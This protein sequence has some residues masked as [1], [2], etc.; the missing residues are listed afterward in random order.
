MNSRKLT[1][2]ILT[3]L[4]A[5]IVAAQVTPQSG[6]LNLKIPL[7]NYS[8]TKN[9]L[10]LDI[11]LSYTGGAGIKV[12]DQASEIGLGWSLSAGGEVVRLKVGEADDQKRL[13]IDEESHVM[14]GI[15]NTPDLTVDDG[16]TKLAWN[17][18][19]PSSSRHT[20]YDQAVHFDREHDV[21]M[22]NIEGRTG[23]FVLAKDLY[24][25][26]LLLEKS[27]IKIVTMEQVPPN[28]ELGTIA[29]FLLTDENGIRYTFQNRLLSAVLNYIRSCHVDPTSF[30]VPFPPFELVRYNVVCDGPP[31]ATPRNIIL[32]NAAYVSQDQQYEVL[33]PRETGYYIADAWYL[34]EIRN[35]QSNKVIKFNYEEKNYAANEDIF[36]STS[37]TDFYSKEGHRQ[38]TLTINENYQSLKYPRLASIEMPGNEKV[39][40]SYNKDRKDNLGKKSL[41]EIRYYE[42]GE[43]K[44]KYE[45]RHGYFY[46]DKMLDEALL[47]AD[48]YNREIALSLTGLK[49]SAPDGTE[50]PE[51]KFEYYTGQQG[52][53]TIIFPERHTFSRDH[54][55]YYNY[56][57]LSN[58]ITNG[59]SH[60]I[61]LPPLDEYLQYP[62]LYRNPTSD[63]NMLQTGMLKKVSTEYGGYTEY[64]YEPNYANNN[65]TDILSGGLRV[66]KI[67]SHE[68][69]TNAVLNTEY[70]YLSNTGFS[71]GD[72]YEVPVYNNDLRGLWITPNYKRYKKAHPNL[73][74]FV[75]AS[76]PNITSLPQLGQTL[77]KRIE[78]KAID[79]LLKSSPFLSNVAVLYRLVTAL[80]ATGLFTT[81]AY[82]EVDF[83]SH[84]QSINFINSNNYLTPTYSR[85]EEITTG[86]VRGVDSRN[87]KSIYEYYS[88]AETPL[89]V[90]T[91][92]FPYSNKTRKISWAY[93]LPKITT[94]MD[95]TGKKVKE[96]EFIYDI[97]QQEF[98]DD[99]YMSKK[100]ASPISLVS[101]DDADNGEYFTNYS[102]NVTPEIVRDIYYPIIGT[103]LLKAEKV[104]VYD[105][106]GVYNETVSNM[107]YNLQNY[108]QNYAKSINS[109]GN[110]IEIKT[111]FPQDYT[112]PGALSDMTLKNIVAPAVSSE[113][114]QTK[115]GGTPELLN[116]TV[117]EYSTALNGDYVPGKLY[118]LQSA[119]PVALAAIGGFNPSQ[120]VRNSSLIVPVS[121]IQYDASGLPTE[122]KDLQGNKTNSTMYDYSSRYPVAEIM[123]AG[124]NEVAYT[125]FETGTTGNWTLGV[126]TI[127]TGRCP[128][129]N[130][131]LVL[132]A[133]NIT[134]S[135]AITKEYILS[136]WATTTD[137]TVNGGISPTLTGPTLNGWT[138][139][140]YRLPAGSATTVIST[141]NNYNCKIDELRLYP[142]NATIS[143]AT[144]KVF[145][146]KTSTCD[147]NNRLKYF[148]YDGLGRLLKEKDELG[149]VVKT[150]EYHYKQ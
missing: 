54:W 29:G 18:S 76:V 11:S 111:Y 86:T 34:S 3:L 46:K 8:D 143:T 117:A 43:L 79:M 24:K 138:L 35:L 144:Y 90:P 42:S 49:K 23:K 17:P 65:G 1:L 33:V 109:M 12:N 99:R 89:L 68:P 4:V 97:Q 92:A 102:G 103:S 85:V 62:E 150:Y 119:A 105:K 16:Q 82:R 58:N 6:T 66:K 13:D 101:P 95:E 73:F 57:S 108:Q 52:S 133:S 45:L 80:R 7:V 60:I 132:N 122:A 64:E 10:N 141:M 53:S 106:S 134:S 148:E 63:I 70:R 116:T 28:T 139:Y 91:L 19:Y 61:S 72:G 113:I 140:Q 120:L 83:K 84:S 100:I 130:K 75:A 48:V 98:R 112:I 56:N 77:K 135:I 124:I 44:Y 94:L 14:A 128:T 20:Y 145:A 129:G 59:N 25:T 118:K 81:V 127:A 27:G 32:E 38:L 15:F 2:V 78:G 115:P 41:D 69:E 146:G 47:P 39:E 21:F 114:W 93:G 123:N 31:E 110:T 147:V 37:A 125:S 9:K 50:L 36:A 104:R 136:F 30:F 67:T 96:T 5:R 88:T 71:S 121:T 51:K 40:F 22:Y 55:G 26:P 137:F 126:N 107:D 149:N 131:F 74:S 142:S 87:G